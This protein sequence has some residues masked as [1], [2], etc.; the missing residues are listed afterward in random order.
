MKTKNEKEIYQF[1]S[2]NSIPNVFFKTIGM[3]PYLK[4][5]SDHDHNRK[6]TLLFYIGFVNLFLLYVGEIIM[7]V[8]VFGN[9][10]N[11]VEITDIAMCVG[12]ISIAFVKV[13]TIFSNT[14]RMSK[15]INYLEF[16][17]PKSIDEQHKFNVKKYVHKTKRIM[18]SYS[19]LF[20]TMI[21]CYN[22]FAL[23][24]SIIGYVRFGNWNAD[25][26][27][28]I[29]YPFDPYEKILFEF[30][31]LSQVWAGYVSAAATLS[32]DLLLCGAVIQVCMH[33]DNLKQDL[34]L[35]K[36]TSTKEHHKHDYII[37]IQYIQRHNKIIRY[38][39]SIKYRY[40]NICIVLNYG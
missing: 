16:E 13:A 4:D 12:F 39:Y 32:S 17:F 35:L 8:K 2:F 40:Y 34:L 29:W 5:P 23:A 10:Q 9:F 21:W 36:P 15:L 31:Y 28:V 6:T 18:K 24:E 14:K 27:Y 1:K 38:K 20:M 3:K 7:I 19:I 37:L 11:F 25:F 22:L 30:N 26:P 33:Y